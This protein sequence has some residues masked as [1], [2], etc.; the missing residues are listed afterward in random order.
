MARALTCVFI[1][2]K[3]WNRRERDVNGNKERYSCICGGIVIQWRNNGMAKDDDI[4]VIGP[5]ENECNPSSSRCYSQTWACSRQALSCKKY[6]KK[7]YC[8]LVQNGTLDKVTVAQLLTLTSWDVIAMV[9]SCSAKYYHR[10][11][12]RTVATRRS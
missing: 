5:D 6:K 10:T 11:I 4:F 7:H 1:K 9:E 8:S 3:E 2:E 12:S